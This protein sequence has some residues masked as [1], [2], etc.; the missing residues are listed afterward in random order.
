[1]IKRLVTTVAVCAALTGTASAQRAPQAA[2]E[3]ADMKEVA[4]YRLTVPVLQKV[5]AVSQ[6]MA[7]AMAKDPKYKQYIA[8]KKELDALRKKDEPTEAD[9]QRMQTL[10]EQIEKMDPSNDMSDKTDS[11]NSL[12]DMER[13]LARVPHLSDA[14]KQAGLTPR[15]F[16]KFELCALQAGMIAAFQKS[17]QTIKLPDGIQPENVQFMKDHEAE[18]TK[19][20]DV[21]QGLGK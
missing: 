14:L 5:A 13:S 19:I 10:E 1:M 6:A 3:D 17:G 15:E 16:A 7:D 9:E 20:N 18:F 12:A 4:A 2:R 21:M 8:A 11:A